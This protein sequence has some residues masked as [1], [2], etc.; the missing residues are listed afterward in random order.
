MNDLVICD[1]FS[2]DRVVEL[3]RARGFGIEIQSLYDSDPVSGKNGSMD[4]RWEALNEI[5][6]RCMRGP[7]GDLFPCSFDLHARHTAG[8]RYG[9]AMAS[10]EKLN[11]GHMV[12]YHGYVPGASPTSGWLKQYTAFWN[13][14]L[15]CVPDSM[16]FHL[17]NILE[18]DPVLISDAV[19]SINDPRVDV[20]LN[21]GHAHC[22]SSTDVIEW[23]RHL[24]SQIGYVHLHD[25]HGERDDH[26]GL[27]CGTI[28]MV[29]ICQALR[30][31]CPNAIWA[32]E[33][34]FS[35]VE[36][37]LEWLAKNEFL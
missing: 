4:T 25:N 16:S 19:A 18:K 22:Y 30:E 2:Y 34:E 33:M 7:H 35:A 37:S 27:G 24:A 9:K 1:K 6:L 15:S 5:P 10:A 20:C 13:D 32:L 21:I 23:I 17:E 31:H 11:I 28:P 36:P 8:E 3:C 26:L 12:L 14:F 29:E